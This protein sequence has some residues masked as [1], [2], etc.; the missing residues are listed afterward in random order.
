MTVRQVA[1]VNHV[2]ARSVCFRP[3]LSWHPAAAVQLLDS[4]SNTGSRA[5]RAAE[6]CFAPRQTQ[7]TGLLLPSAAEIYQIF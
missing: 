7:E 3:S 5:E 1:A 6:Q 4:A 2:S